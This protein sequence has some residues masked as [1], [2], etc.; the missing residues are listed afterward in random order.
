M[1]WK[2]GIAMMLAAVLCW[3]AYGAEIKVLGSVVV[4]GILRDGI[5]PEF[6]RETGNKVV[7]EFAGNAIVRQRIEQGETFDL[8]ILGPPSAI[9]DLA[10]SGVIA[11]NARAPFGRASL[12]MSVR[13]GA[14][15]PD[16]STVA[17]FKTTLQSVKSVAMTDPKT[18]G[19]PAVYLLK[20]AGEKLGMRDEFQSKL[21]PTK[22]GEVGSAVAEGRAEIGIEGIPE[23]VT[24]NGVALV[25][26]LPDEVQL[27]A[28]F[29]IGVSARSKEPEAARQLLKFLSSPKG[30]EAIKAR[31]ME[32][33]L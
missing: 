22:A 7:A 2:P 33:G 32:P 29:A 1:N 31:G 18:A 5:I 4:Q 11:A 27:R 9:D 20:L 12:G 30:I 21:Y 14:P 8:V 19:I 3:P 25:G 16:I 10:K 6:E 13:S 23:I 17:A 28:D 24:E 26:P 15:K